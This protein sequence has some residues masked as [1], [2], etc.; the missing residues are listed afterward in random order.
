MEKLRLE[1]ECENLS[2]WK[3]MKSY[4]NMILENEKSYQNGQF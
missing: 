3:A 1:A 2:K 4:L